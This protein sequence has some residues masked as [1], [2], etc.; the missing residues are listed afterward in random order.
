MSIRTKTLLAPL[1]ASL[2]LAPLAGCQFLIWFDAVMRPTEPAAALYEIEDPEDKILLVVID[3]RTI[4]ESINCARLREELTEALN[5]EFLEHDVV[6]QAISHDSVQALYI[7]HPQ[8]RYSL[9]FADMAQATGADVVLHVKLLQF[10]LQESEEGPIWNGRLETA[11]RL[12][13]ADGSVLWP[14]DRPVDGF[15]VER[16]T[17]A[18]SMNSSGTYAI[19]LTR[20]LAE[21]QADKIA[22][23]FY[24][25]EVPRGQTER[26]E[27]EFSAEF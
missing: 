19:Q 16:T 14:R 1:L 3:D 2:V 17:L 8:Y 7:S 10:R 5:Q 21:D 26:E 13:D 4:D 12:L 9:P 22:K 15:T 24:E 23:L 6:G 11:V 20:D 27:H 25:H 18:N